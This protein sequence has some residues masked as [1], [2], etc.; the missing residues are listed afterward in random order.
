MEE[1]RVYKKK[2]LIGKSGQVHRFSGYSFAHYDY[3]YN[4]KIN[5]IYYIGLTDD[6]NCVVDYFQLN[7]SQQLFDTFDYFKR[8]LLS[9]SK[10]SNYHFFIYEEHDEDKVKIESVLDDLNLEKHLKPLF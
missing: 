9:D 2:N 5:G 8:N 7:F 3:S 1:L 4:F 6:Y 10:F